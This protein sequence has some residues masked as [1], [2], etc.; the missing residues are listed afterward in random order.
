MAKYKPLKVNI[1]LNA[2]LLS[3]QKEHEKDNVIMPPKKE[4]KPKGPLQANE[5]N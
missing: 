3:N 1:T 4:N 5:D 2:E